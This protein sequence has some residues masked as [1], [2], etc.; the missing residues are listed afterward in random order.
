MASKTFFNGGITTSENKNIVLKSGSGG[1]INLLNH[2]NNTEN[3]KLILPF[4]NPTD[5]VFTNGS[6]RV[7]RWNPDKLSELQTNSEIYIEFYDDVE[8]AQ[9][10][11]NGI[12]NA[13][14]TIGDL[15][16]SS[17]L[18][19]TNIYSNINT[20]L[21]TTNG[22][23]TL[24]SIS[25]NIDITS[26]T[27]DENFINLNGGLKFK[28]GNYPNI[29]STDSNNRTIIS[30]AN[31][32]IHLIA[33]KTDFFYELPNTD[34]GRFLNLYFTNN[35]TGTAN[36]TANTSL[37]AGSG[38][39]NGLLFNNTGQSVQLIYI[40]LTGSEPNFVSPGWRIINCG[41]GVF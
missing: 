8:L 21:Q 40:G 38:S 4:N 34:N 29:G 23:I 31:T 12:V 10:V 1:S 6:S 25:S 28:V 14:A 13:T 24:N 32:H 22:D 30:T 18:A 3:S 35:T 39:V 41:A 37:F 11:S 15:T 9:N 5:N 19:N 17:T 20:T 33:D 26:G 27:D 2:P 7:L 36:V 16:L